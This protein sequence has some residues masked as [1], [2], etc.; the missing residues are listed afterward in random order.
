[1]CFLGSI[2]ILTCQW[3]SSL[4]RS[5]DTVLALS[6]LIKRRIGPELKAPI[7]VAGMKEINYEP[8][9]GRHYGLLNVILKT[10]GKREHSV[11]ELMEGVREDVDRLLR[12]RGATSWVLERLLEGPP[13]GADIDLK[14]QSPDWEMSAAVSRSIRDEL[15]RHDGIVDIQDDFT[16]E[17]Q[18]MEITVD[19]AKAKRLGIDQDHLIMTVQAAF[20]GLNVATY[21]QG[22]D[23]QDVRLKYMLEYRRD[24]DDLVNLKVVVPGQGEVPL[25]EIAHVQLTPGF[26]S[27]GHYNGKQTVRLTANIMESQENQK[28]VSGFLSN[29]RG[30]KMTAVRANRIAR[31]H[32][33]RISPDFPGARFIAGGLQDETNKSLKQLGMAA[34][35]ALFLIFFIL[36]LQFNSFSQP[37]VIMI[38]I[39][40]VTLGVMVGLIVSNNPLTFVTLIGLLTLTGIVVNDSLVLIDFINRYR[41]EHPGQLYLAIV[42]GC[43][44]RL[45]PIILT[46]LTTI[47]GLAPMAFGLGGKSVFWAPL[48]TAIIWGLGFATLLILSMVP[49]Y[50]AILEDIR[51]LLR[52]RKRRT[53]DTNR[54]IREAFEH[55]ELR[56]Y[57]K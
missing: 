24:F 26:H 14:I 12:S 27:I 6:D 52:H 25:K 54:E 56:P 45:R 47:F 32:F 34:I 41:R 42:R 49:A 28:G 16:R 43:H 4:N 30:S 55:E 57:M 48:A 20:Y 3:G 8:I 39:P 50:Y 29:L 9:F 17:K 23:E 51:Y 7:A 19:E 46:S 5:R 10:G 44:V 1:M 21:N 33:D 35:M 15:A 2:F 31:E 53:E 36:A 11:L 40:F 18:F 37:F 38:T 22:E 13:V